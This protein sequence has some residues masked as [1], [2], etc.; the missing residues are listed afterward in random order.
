[1][2]LWGYKGFIRILIFWPSSGVVS[3]IMYSL[4]L[5]ILLIKLDAPIRRK[6]TYTAIGALGTYFANVLRIALIIL[7]VTYISLDVKTFHDSIGEIIFLTWIL[8]FLY[9]VISRENRLSRKSAKSPILGRPQVPVNFINGS[10]VNGENEGS[11][12]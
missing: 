10:R 12:P 4:V 9:L 2:S 6:V 11:A 3:M 1:L 5:V 8:G 7:Y